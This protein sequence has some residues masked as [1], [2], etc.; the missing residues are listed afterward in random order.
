MTLR[1]FLTGTTFAIIAGAVCWL[2]VVTQL[3]PGRAGLLGFILF[4]L[5][6]FVAAASLASLVGFTVRR[7]LVRRQFVAYAV[8]TSLRQ[9]TM[10]GIFLTVLLCLQLLRVYRW[11]L[12][13]ILLVLFISFELIFL[14]YDRSHARK[15]ISTPNPGA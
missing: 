8:R 2:L 5:S 10:I 3:D 4:F 7:L 15:T 13:V 12:A 11:W 14:S 1:T 6:L 9:G